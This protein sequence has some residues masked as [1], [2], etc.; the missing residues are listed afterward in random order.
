MQGSAYDEGYEAYSAGTAN[1]HEKGTDE[2]TDWQ[3]G[4]E[5]A[6]FEAENE[7]ED[8]EDDAE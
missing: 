2:Y 6:E 4:W 7:D 5:D 8:V 3:A 1:P